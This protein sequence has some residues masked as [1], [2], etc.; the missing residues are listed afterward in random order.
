MQM[1]R[2]G[3]YLCLGR[4]EILGDELDGTEERVKASRGHGRH[5]QAHGDLLLRTEATVEDGWRRVGF[6]TRS[7]TRVAVPVAVGP[8]LAYS[9]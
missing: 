1:E 6:S 7:W 8:P 5:A 4:E 9:I 3:I 2:N